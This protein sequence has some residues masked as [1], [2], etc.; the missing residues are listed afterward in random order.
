MTEH[1]MN[2]GVRSL[3]AGPGFSSSIT[4]L[5]SGVLLITQLTMPSR[6]NI[7]SRPSLFCWIR[8]ASAQSMAPAST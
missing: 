7:F 2:G 4:Q 8:R 6:I 3:V 5:C 1:L